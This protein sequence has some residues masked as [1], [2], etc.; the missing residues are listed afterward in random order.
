MNT[1]AQPAL[2]DSVWKR[3]LWLYGAY[4]LLSN[5]AYLFGYYVLPE[6]FMRGSL[7]V[8]VGRVAATGVFW[9]EMALTLLFNLGIAGTVIILCNLNQVKGFPVGYIIPISLGIFSGLIAG[10]NSFG[11]SDLR[12]FNAWDGMA[13]SLSI[14]N[15]EML[16]YILIIASTVAFGVYQYRSW[17]RWEGEWKPTKLMSIR[18]MRLSRAELACLLAGILLLVAAAYRETARAL[19]A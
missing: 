12:Q 14:G 15:L 3:A 17:W 5:A 19:G 16:A 6:G 8:A 1:T 13:L 10:T 4:M 11:A 7:Q 9:S 2:R 18:N